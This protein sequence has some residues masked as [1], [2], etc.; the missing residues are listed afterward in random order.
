MTGAF[1]LTGKRS[2]HIVVDV[3]GLSDPSHIV[4][5]SLSLGL[6]ANLV[7]E[8][9]NQCERDAHQQ[10]SDN[11]LNQRHAASWSNA[12]GH[13]SELPRNTK[14]NDSR[15]IVSGSLMRRAIAS[16]D[17]S[18]SREAQRWSSGFSLRRLTAVV[19]RPLH[20]LLTVAGT[21][22]NQLGPRPQ[23]AQAKA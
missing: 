15:Q 10:D 18:F 12:P 1:R 5:G 20:C 3:H 6:T 19:A 8:R 23:L 4:R 7:D 21:T 2:I 11:Q 13:A 22:A 16:L 17:L 9:Q 14:A